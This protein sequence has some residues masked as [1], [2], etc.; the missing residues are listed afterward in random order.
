[1]K[2]SLGAVCCFSKL[3]GFAA[4]R[5]TEHCCTCYNH[6]CLNAGRTLVGPVQAY[7]K[8]TNYMHFAKNAGGVNDHCIIELFCHSSQSAR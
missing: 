3:V 8:F 1:M 7:L 5:A 4:S 6:P 2:I